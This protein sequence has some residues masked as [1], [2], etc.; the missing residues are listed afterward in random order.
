MENRNL[1]N[2]P[3]VRLRG[4]RWGKF[5]GLPAVEDCLQG[6]EVVQAII[7]WALGEAVRANVALPILP[8]GDALIH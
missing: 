5:E 2:S 3:F 7:L 4:P 6:P 1:L 8:L